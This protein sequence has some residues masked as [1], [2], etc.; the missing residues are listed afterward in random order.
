MKN[1]PVSI[2]ILLTPLNRPT[3]RNAPR[4][5]ESAAVTSSVEGGIASATGLNGGRADSLR[6]NDRCERR[7]IIARMPDRMAPQNKCARQKNRRILGV[8]VTRAYFPST[9][10]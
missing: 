8:P 3:L 2:R 6:S 4:Q 9:L 5:E 1:E 10:R 7:S